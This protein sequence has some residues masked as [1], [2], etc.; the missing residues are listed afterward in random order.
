[1]SEVILLKKEE[2]ID[3]SKL[4]FFFR[5]SKKEGMKDNVSTFSC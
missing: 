1:M 2:Q 3:N 5:E 4:G